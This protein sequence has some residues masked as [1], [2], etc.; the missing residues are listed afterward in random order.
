M[1]N[2]KVSSWVNDFLDLGKNKSS[3]YVKGQKNACL[4]FL[5]YTV[6]ACWNMNKQQNAAFVIQKSQ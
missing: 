1:S 4:C 5:K 3:Y 2:W 6:L